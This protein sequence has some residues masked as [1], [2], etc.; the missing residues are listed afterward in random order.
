[1]AKLPGMFQRKGV[2]YVRVMIPLE[3]R[4]QFPGS[5]SQVVESLKTSDYTDAKV[6]ATIRRATHLARFEQV[7][8]ELNPLPLE[9]ITPEMAQVLAERVTARILATDELLRTK[10]EAAVALLEATAPF[11]IPYGL[12]IGPYEPPPPPAFAGPFDPLEDIPAEQ[13]IAVID[14]LAY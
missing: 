8:R 6:K 5:K 7:R 3:L 2:W 14:D 10:P 1:M 12:S 4:G 13:S 11:R 9:R